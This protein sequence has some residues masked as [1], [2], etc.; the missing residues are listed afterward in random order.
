MTCKSIV[1]RRI[2]CRSGFGRDPSLHAIRGRSL[3][4]S[5]KS[6]AALA[7]LLGALVPAWAQDAAPTTAVPGVTPA[8]LDSE[9]WIR[10]QADAD[11]LVLDAEAI[12]RQNR[13]LR[14]SDPSVNQ[15]ES[16]PAMLAAEQVRGWIEGLSVLPDTPLYD[17]DGKALSRRA[18]AALVRSL[19]LGD[20]PAQRKTRYALVTRR[21]DLRTFPTRQ[22]VFSAPGNTDIDRF[23]ENALFPGTPVALVH[24]SR[25]G[26]WWF[27][28]GALYEAWIEQAH[29][30]EGTA[31]AVFAY[32]R[33]EPYLIVTGT[34]ARTVFTPEQPQ[35]SE[36]QLDM[37]VRVPLLREWPADRAV[38][39]QHPFT[40][41]VIELPI[42]GKDG[43]LAFSPALLPRGADVADGYL[44]LRRDL[45][46]RQG[47]KFL[48]E[49][50]GWGHSY[51]ARDCSGFVSEVYRSFGVELPRN[52]RDQATSPAFDRIAFDAG[53]D[54][55]ARLAILRTLDVGDLVYIPGHVMMVVGRERGEPYVIH[56]TTGIGTLDDEGKYE[57]IVLNGVVVTPLVPLMADASTATLDRITSVQRI[58]RIS[59]DAPAGADNKNDKTQP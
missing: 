25:D 24:E 33:R 40:A 58:R 14:S 38:N 17:E 48:G 50:Y 20:I 13:R 31:D 53:M 9:Y 12:A 7:L 32:G 11:A 46:L 30:A 55:A 26:R 39:G 5:C 47:F 6:G 56:D 43:K 36:L 16:L 19:D 37:G 27:V 49:R 44:P 10:K 8:Q 22:R 35:V 3:R 2:Q 28:V 54:R 21:A 42:R 18:R 57:R 15:I 52:T 51:N 23:Q 1:A 45:I 4:R 59:G 34:A 29:V 41:H